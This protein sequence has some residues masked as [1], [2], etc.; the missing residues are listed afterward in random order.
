MRFIC[1]KKKTFSS[2]SGVRRQGKGMR[3]L[4]TFIVWHCCHRT[5]IGNVNLE[6]PLMRAQQIVIDNG[7]RYDDDKECGNFSDKFAG[8]KR[9]LKWINQNSNVLP[10]SH[11]ACDV[12]ILYIYHLPALLNP[13]LTNKAKPIAYCIH[14]S[15]ELLV[16]IPF[17]Y[18]HDVMQSVMG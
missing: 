5:F 1:A 16:N 9:R 2:R 7:Y 15:I 13:P 17:Y 12:F 6:I 3:R 8:T 4:N 14:I 10:S 11:A 18:G